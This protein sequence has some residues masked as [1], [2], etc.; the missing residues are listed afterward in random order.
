MSLTRANATTSL[1]GVIVGV[2][3]SYAPDVRTLM[4]MSRVCREWGRATRGL[5]GIW[6][7]HFLA[8]YDLMWQRREIYESQEDGV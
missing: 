7:G 5:D 4:R 8:L 1:T 2:I 6:K 3:A